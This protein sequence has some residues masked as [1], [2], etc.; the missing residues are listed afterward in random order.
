MTRNEGNIDRFAR[1]VFGI[2]LLS[3]VF[4]GPRTWFGLIGIVPLVT[5][6]VG[7]CPLYTVLGIRTCPTNS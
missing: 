5:G 2:A 6:F 4:L 3:L 7:Y 1:I